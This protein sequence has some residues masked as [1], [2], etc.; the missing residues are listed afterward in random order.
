M[1]N[2]LDKTILEKSEGLTRQKIQKMIKSGRVKVDGKVVLKSNKQ[3]EESSDI[4]F[5]IPKEK[6]LNLKAQ[7][8]ALD[9]V[10]EDK[11]YLIINKPAG[12]VVHPAPGHKEGT[13]VN[14]ILHH[15]KGKTS[16]QGD[17][18]RPG[19]LHRLDKDTSGVIVI[20]KNDSAHANFSKQMEERSIEK[21]Y[22]TLVHGIIDQKGIIEAPI[23]RHHLKRQSMTVSTSGK[24]AITE[25]KP[26]KAF[27]E[28]DMTLLEVKIKTGRTHQIRVHLSKIGYPVVGDSKYGKKSEELDRQ[29]LHAKSI[30]FKGVD[31]KKKIYSGELPEKLNDYL[32]ILS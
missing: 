3:V 19:L 12:M 27:P 11:D 6:P 18:V 31:G 23:G 16:K 15:L 8:I 14:A 4:Q 9:I 25:F 20:A 17:A 29:F 5:S 13:L 21:T 2:R 7:K 26:V 24:D 1:K 28:S 22:I 10:H 32:S 30:R